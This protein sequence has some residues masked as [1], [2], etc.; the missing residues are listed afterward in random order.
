MST[1]EIRKQGD[2]P[3]GDDE[4]E[5]APKRRRL[6]EEAETEDGGATKSFSASPQPVTGSS[7]LPFPVIPASRFYPTKASLLSKA[8][9]SVQYFCLFSPDL[10]ILDFITRISRVAAITPP[11]SSSR[12]SSTSHCIT[13]ERRRSLIIHLPAGQSGVSSPGSRGPLNC[14]WRSM[15]APAAFPLRTVIRWGSGSTW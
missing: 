4:E 10:S 12:S 1:K 14:R 13:R 8:S 5:N 9:R 11:R 7:P 2:L 6:T 3:A 15:V